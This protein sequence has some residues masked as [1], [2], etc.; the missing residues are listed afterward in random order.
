MMHEFSSNIAGVM[1]TVSLYGILHLYAHSGLNLC[2]QKNIE[3]CL[4]NALDTASPIIQRTR[5]QKKIVFTSQS[6]ASKPSVPCH[7][8]IIV[9]L[10]SITT[11]MRARRAPRIIMEYCSYIL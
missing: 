3:K 7:C 2:Q 11:R 1:E 6:Y 9:V 4:L 10:H 8:S 5:T